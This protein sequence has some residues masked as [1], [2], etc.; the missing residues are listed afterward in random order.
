M[1][2]PTTDLHMSDIGHLLRVMDRLVDSGNTLIAIEHNL[3]AIRNADWIID[4]GPEAAARAGN[5]SS[6]GRRRIC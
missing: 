4:M 2:E 1:D 6:R 5:C 3:D